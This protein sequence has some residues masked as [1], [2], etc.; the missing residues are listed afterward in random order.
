MFQIVRYREAEAALSKC[1]TFNPETA[2]E[3]LRRIIAFHDL[4]RV[5]K[6]L[7]RPIPRITI[8]ISTRRVDL[9]K[10]DQK[11][12]SMLQRLFPLDEDMM[13]NYMDG[14]SMFDNMANC[15]LIPEFHGFY[16][17]WDEIAEF[18]EDESIGGYTES[19]SVPLF[20]GAF[21]NEFEED[22]WDR[23]NEYFGWGVPW[24][25]PK[26]GYVVDLAKL[27][28]V[29]RESKEIKFDAEFLQ[30]IF[31]DTGLIFYDFNPYAE[32]PEEPPELRWS[33]K[34]IMYLAQEWTKAKKIED[35]MPYNIQVG[36]DTRQLKL[37]LQAMKDCERKD[38]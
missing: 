2:F 24:P 33:Y 30:V 27:Y 15:L 37:L 21:M 3:T 4:A 35:R 34:S 31:Q 22:I 9:S 36:Q 20:C 7:K 18:V 1:T 16:T 38:R 8:P 13:M 25:A 26:N 12:M 23:F 11:I 19:M 32:D 17:S 28:K 29:V 5:Y 10:V 6:D 14:E